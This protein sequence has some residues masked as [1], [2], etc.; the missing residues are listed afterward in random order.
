M[1]QESPHWSCVCGKSGPSAWWDLGVT[2]LAFW[3]R[4]G[5]GDLTLGLLLYLK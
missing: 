5:P 1:S 3:N 2:G 4:L